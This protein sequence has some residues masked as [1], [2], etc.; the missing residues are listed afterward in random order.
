MAQN[1]PRISCDFLVLGTTSSGKT[2]LVQ[3]LK[4]L[5]KIEFHETFPSNGVNID[6]FKLIPYQP[7][8]YRE[9][10]QVNQLKNEHVQQKQRRNSTTHITS[11]NLTFDTIKPSQENSHNTIKEANL[12]LSDLE[13]DSHSPT[14]DSLLKSERIFHP[15][16]KS[17]KNSIVT[18]KE[19]IKENS[20]EKI[21]SNKSPPKVDTNRITIASS[22]HNTS[23]SK[24]E[25][26]KFTKI[27]PTKHTTFDTIKS[28]RDHKSEY[29]NIA[30]IRRNDFPSNTSTHHQ[31]L[32]RI[33]DYDPQRHESSSVHPNPNQPQV[34]YNYASTNRQ[35]FIFK[36]VGGSLT[37]TWYRYASDCHVIVLTIDASQSMMLS[38]SVI[39]FLKLL[40]FEKPIVCV[41]TKIDMPQTYSGD[42]WK[43]MSR[44]TELKSQG[45][46]IEFIEVS[47]MEGVQLTHLSYLLREVHYRS[48]LKQITK[49]DLSKK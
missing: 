48:F 13:M 44:F 15:V 7:Q 27:S 40:H 43:R 22:K 9:Q 14:Y 24:L 10:H 1:G 23:H 28:S 25:L 12:S 46:D 47:S 17:A 3:Q 5:P 2:Y 21:K 32:Q 16:E 19:K 8:E 26:N 20:K 42:L 33:N 49:E 6:E 35:K 4:S 18:K 38:Q 39:E 11:A 36:E 37:S 29:L 34:T 41:L 30:T 31:F 45:K